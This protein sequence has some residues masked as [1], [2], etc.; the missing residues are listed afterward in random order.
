[1]HLNA[2]RR[3]EDSGKQCGEVVKWYKVHAHKRQGEGRPRLFRVARRSHSGYIV[4][5]LLLPLWVSREVV[6]RGIGQGYPTSSKDQH[7]ASLHC[8]A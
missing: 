1:M 6:I 3:R 7:A 4:S 8:S 5:R 2:L